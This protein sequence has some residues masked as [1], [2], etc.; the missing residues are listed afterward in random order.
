MDACDRAYVSSSFGEK[1]LNLTARCKD[2]KEMR[3]LVVEIRAE[4]SQAAEDLSGIDG[5]PGF[6]VRRVSTGLRANPDDTLALVLDW[7]T[8][9]G[10]DTEMVF[11]VTPKSTATLLA[12]RSTEKTKKATSDY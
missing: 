3:N 5:V 10:K 2:A 4:I 1:G 6:R 12:E 11:L 8:K 9:D 7:K